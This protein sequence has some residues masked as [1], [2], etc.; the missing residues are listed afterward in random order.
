MKKFAWKIAVSVAVAVGTFALAVWS[1]RH[2][3]QDA[4]AVYIVLNAGSAVIPGP[5][6]WGVYVFLILYARRK[7]RMFLCLLLYHLGGLVI[8][9]LTPFRTSL[10]M[11]ASLHIATAC[12]AFAAVYIYLGKALHKRSAIL[13]LALFYGASFLIAAAFIEDFSQQHARFGPPALVAVL[14]NVVVAFMGAAAV[15][16]YIRTAPQASKTGKAI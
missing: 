1:S 13:S 12:L 14:H 11:L 16:L 7:W 3:G 10:G 4:L 8:V 9:C 5:L 6:V 15:W 2:L